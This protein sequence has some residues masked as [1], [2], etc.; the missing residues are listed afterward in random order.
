MFLW[1]R[2]LIVLLERLRRYH[3][4]Y[5][6]SVVGNPGAGD[7]EFGGGIGSAKV[8][9]G[10]EDDGKGAAEHICWREEI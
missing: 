2:C 3:D 8:G 6:S 10:F 9:S 1:K 7:G 5:L 4:D